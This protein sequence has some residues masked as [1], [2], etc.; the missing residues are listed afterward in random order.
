M[1]VLIQAIGVV[2]PALRRR[3]QTAIGMGMMDKLMDML[4]D[5]LVRIFE[6]ENAQERPVHKGAIAVDI[7]A[8]RPFRHRVEQGIHL[9][10]GLTQLRLHTFALG[11]IGVGSDHA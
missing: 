5:D 11:N 7:D 10:M 1:N 8:I 4:A 9:L 6:A 2:H 3:I